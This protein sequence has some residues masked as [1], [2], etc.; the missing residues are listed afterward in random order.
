MKKLNVILSLIL[1]AVL[2]VSVF[3]VP[4]YALESSSLPGDANGDGKVDVMDVTAIQRHILKLSVLDDESV[5]RAKVCG[6][7]GLSII[8]AT[9]IQRYIVG[10]I[11]AF[12]AEKPETESVT[13]AKENITIYFTNNK[14]WETVNARFFNRATGDSE[15]AVMKFLEKNGDGEDVYSADV[16]VSKYDRVVFGDGTDETTD[17][18]VTKASSGYFIRPETKRYNGKLLAGV[19]T[20]GEQYPGNIDTVVMDYPDG[21]EKDIYIWTPEDYDPKNRSK[22]Y[23]VLYLCDGQNLF[24]LTR[25]RTIHKWRCD[26]SVL[27]LMNNGGDG[28]IIV[29]VASNGR[30][31]F[32]ELTPEIGEFTS[33]MP[34]LPEGT[35]LNGEIFSDFMINKV[36]PYVE[37]NY[38]TNSI[39]GISG[40]SNGGIEAFYIGMEHPDKFS[41]VGAISPALDFFEP[42]VWGEYFAEKDFSGRVPKIYFYS[43]NSDMIE[44][45]QCEATGKME[46]TL[47]A[48]GY[49]ADKFTVVIDDDG[50]HSEDFWAIYFPEMLSYGLNF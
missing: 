20:Y 49:P 33:S 32:N 17:T 25:T 8:D 6:Y 26:E 43:G 34:P 31:R 40:S 48:A 38:N 13:K 3:S 36:I 28:I 50:A 30:Y 35:E 45:I 23:S 42:E 11:S 29:G 46:T 18:P 39:R 41:Y 2:C 1:T 12:P 9:A 10:L 21:Y 44:K 7:S 14:N 5:E 4:S 27:S 19:Y 16:D 22:R 15:T 37:L 47:K 24:D